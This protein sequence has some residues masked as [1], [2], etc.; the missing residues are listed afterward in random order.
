MSGA[1]LVDVGGPRAQT[2]V[3][4]EDTRGL[5]VVEAMWTSTNRIREPVPSVHTASDGS[6]TNHPE[7][8]DQVCK[9]YTVKKIR[10]AGGSVDADF[11]KPEV[12]SGLQGLRPRGGR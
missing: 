11:A 6:G 8:E 5:E 10:L 3:H 4:G 2:S 9:V 12:C 1:D 7:D